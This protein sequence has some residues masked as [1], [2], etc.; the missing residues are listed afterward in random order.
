MGSPV[1]APSP[2]ES[3]FQ[4]Y[5]PVVV[6]VM[7]ILFVSLSVWPGHM[8]AD[9]LNQ[10]A[11]ARSGHFL[12]WWA[13]VLDWMW[14][15][16]FLLHLSP[17]FVLLTSTT[18]FILSLFEILRC[19]LSR[20]AA[21]GATLLITAYPPVFGF[22]CSLQRDTWFGA[23]NLAAYALAL[24]CLRRSDANVRFLIG[25]SLTAVW[26]GMA[27]RQNGFIALA[28]VVTLDLYLLWSRRPSRGSH[29]RSTNGVKGRSRWLL[30]PATI[31]TILLFA[32]SQY[33]LTYEVIGAVRT[34]PQQELFYGDLA[35]LSVGT[36]QNL[37]PRFIYPSQKFK[38]LAAHTS[39]FSVLPL[40]AGPGHPLVR[41]PDA[42][43]Y[44]SFVSGHEDSSLEHDWLNAIRAHP[45]A[46][47]SE[48]WTLWAH[49]IGLT[50]PSY[51]PFHP[52]F[53]TNPWGYR[54]SFGPMDRA[55]LSYLSTFESGN[56]IGGPLFRVWPYLL[57]G[58][59]VTADLVRKR[60]SAT[61]R[62][63]GCMCGASVVYYLGYAVAAMGSGYRWAWTTV[64]VVVL[65]VVMD[66]VDRL[67]GWRSRTGRLVK[68]PVEAPEGDGQSRRKATSSGQAVSV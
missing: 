13:P 5:G 20:W 65:A 25:L 42:A 47:V 38:E 63:V 44:P 37:E 54:A 50:A 66:G 43:S 23:L 7:A 2:K 68:D 28:P 51:E 21:V 12:D 26:F 55:V 39:P 27:A 57:I 32:A 3:A 6:L 4:R 49:L 14:R 16:L 52:G 48:R 45:G 19:V 9:A 33:V 10:I 46:Y 61:L 53:D 56:L 18:I 59:A 15:L 41:T 30:L 8:D 64:V 24:R 29:A 67:S 22:L 1:L 58:V 35:E 11:M 40:I 36:H 17:G 60:R 34:Y 62:I 31:A